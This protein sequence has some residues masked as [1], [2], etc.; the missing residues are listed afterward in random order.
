MSK[1][2][3]IRRVAVRSYTLLKRFVRDEVVF[4]PRRFGSGERALP[5]YLILGAMK[6]GTTSLSFYLS[7]NPHILPAF[8]K[9]VRY[10]D[11]RFHRGESWYRSHFPRVA[12]LEAAERAAGSNVIT[13]EATPNYLFH[14]RVP[15]LLY[16][17]V[18]QARLVAILRNPIE[19]A[20][21]HYNHN[22]RA[23]RT[24][25]Q[26]PEPLSFSDALYAEEERLM[27]KR[28]QMLATP[29]YDDMDYLRFS[30]MNQGVYVDQLAA[31][32]ELFGRERLLVLRSEDFYPDP[33]SVL[34]TVTDFLE[35]ERHQVPDLAAKNVN[36]YSNMDPEAR[37]YMERFF[38]PHN[39][40]LYEFL[41][42]D[43]HWS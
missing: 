28:E 25:G 38:A 9:E 10:F 18:P 19:R 17:T 32:A 30:Y 1:V 2:S 23:E 36:Q 39:R 3:T 7:Q 34:N 31:F 29:G 37:H 8:R 21:S 15:T 42:R 27:G 14:P 6:S 22:R 13:G 12:S 43:M 16:E 33:Q 35:V 5:D 26:E 20:F 11:R 24:L 4:L 41:G 40:R